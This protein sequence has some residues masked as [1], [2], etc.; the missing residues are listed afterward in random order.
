MTDYCIVC[1][2]DVVKD[3]MKCCHHIAYSEK[4]AK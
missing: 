2:Q 1:G 4:W 3:P